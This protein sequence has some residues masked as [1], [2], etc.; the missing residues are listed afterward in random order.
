[1]TKSSDG[2]D[3]AFCKQ[4]KKVLQPRKSSLSQHEKTKEHQSR[5]E[6][7]PRTSASGLSGFVLRTRKMPEKT[8]EAEVKLAVAIACHCSIVAIDHL[9]EVIKGLGEGSCL[10]HIRLHR[11]KC[12]SLLKRVVGPSL[13][14]ELKEDMIGQKYSLLCD[15][16][17]DVSVAKYLCVSAKYYSQI[18]KAVCTVFLKLVPVV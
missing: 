15:E 6:S 2:L 18:R 10:E 7:A 9:S 11:T 4:C 1:M 13:A 16:S 17:T 3:N 5:I 14:E 12:T 8:K